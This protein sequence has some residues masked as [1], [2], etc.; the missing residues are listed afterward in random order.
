MDKESRIKAQWQPYWKQDLTALKLHGLSDRR[1]KLISR[2]QLSAVIITQIALS[3]V[4][5]AIL[6]ASFICHDVFHG[7]HFDEST[8]YRD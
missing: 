2:L 4:Y 5:G 3:G 7:P 1:I 6:V 8:S